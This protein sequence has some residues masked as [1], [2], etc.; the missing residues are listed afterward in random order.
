LGAVDLGFY[1]RQL[2]ER[3]CAVNAIPQSKIQA[4]IHG[5]CVGLGVTLAAA[6]GPQHV[7]QRARIAPAGIDRSR[8]VTPE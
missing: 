7:D 8:S 5:G 2:F 3:G 4:G 1:S 6:K